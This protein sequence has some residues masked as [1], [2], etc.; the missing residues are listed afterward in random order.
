MKVLAEIAKGVTVEVEME[1]GKEALLKAIE[2][3]NKWCN[4]C[5]KVKDDFRL[6]A[7]TYDDITYIKRICLDCG[8]ASN[9]GS[10]KVGGT[11]FWKKFEKY[12]P[13]EKNGSKSPVAQSGKAQAVMAEI[14]KGTQSRPE[15]PPHTDDDLPF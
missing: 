8:C 15:A 9:L 1:D 5:E 12:D 4:M 6:Y 3:A 10:N 7:R 11:Y 14:E 2:L 13:D